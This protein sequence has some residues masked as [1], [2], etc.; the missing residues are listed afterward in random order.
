MGLTRPVDESVSALKAMLLDHLKTHSIND[1]TS[2]DQLCELMQ[3][4]NPSFGNA[5]VFPSSFLPHQLNFRHK[6]DYS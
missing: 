2:L 6:K 5:S 1:S 4:E 3:Q